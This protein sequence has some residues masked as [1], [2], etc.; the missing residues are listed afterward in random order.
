LTPGAQL[1]RVR[2]LALAR[3]QSI[4]RNDQ[5]KPL[6]EDGRRRLIVAGRFVQRD[7]PDARRQA[8]SAFKPF[9]YA[10]ALDYGLTPATLV[11]DAPFALKQ[12]D[13]TM[14]TPENY[15]KEFFGATTLRAGLEKSRNLMTIRLAYEM[16]MD[17]VFKYGR[18]LDVYAPEGLPK[19]DTAEACSGFLSY[20]L[21]AGETTLWRMVKGYATF[22]NGGKRVEPTLI[23]RVQDRDGKTVYK[24]DQRDCS[25]CNGPFAG[26]APP[27]IPD[28]R[29]QI[30]DPIT[31]YQVTSMLEGVVDRGTGTVIKTVGK[32]LAGKTGT[33]NDYKDAWFVGYTGGFVTAVWVGKDDNSAMRG[34][35]GGSSPAAIW[36]GCLRPIETP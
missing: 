32:P 17:R 33:T 20:A 26:G 14:W 21:G 3:Q 25:T 13:G 8:G 12:A 23:D 18:D 30:L 1:D 6:G 35:T 7:Q 16:G 34:V 29:A 36:R 27:E 15:T 5:A 4:K 31:A 24:H 10:A 28:V 2:R 11:E 19:C 9:V 22:V